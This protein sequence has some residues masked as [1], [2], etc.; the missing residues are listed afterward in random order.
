VEL[1]FKVPELFDLIEPCMETVKSATAIDEFNAFRTVLGDPAGAYYGD[2]SY[3]PA[4]AFIVRFDPAARITAP[5]NNALSAC[6]V[7]SHGFSL[8]KAER[9]SH[10][11]H[12]YTN[13]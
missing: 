2:W 7:R 10:V 12:I 5:A 8:E 4:T 3:A 9:A 11:S 13:G 6:Y 1:T